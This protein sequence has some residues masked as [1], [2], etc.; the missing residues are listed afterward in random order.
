MGIFWTP[1]LEICRK[2]KRPQLW[3]SVKG[4]IL[5]ECFKVEGPNWKE[6]TFKT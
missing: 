1:K 5:G 4:E 3:K 6:T 2:E